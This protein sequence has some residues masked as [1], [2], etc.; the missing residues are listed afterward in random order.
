MVNKMM[1]RPILGTPIKSVKLKMASIITPR[2][3]AIGPKNPP[4]W[5]KIIPFI[6]LCKFK[7]QITSERRGQKRGDYTK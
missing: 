6:Y 1:E 7:I 4:C 3:F 2:T 5:V